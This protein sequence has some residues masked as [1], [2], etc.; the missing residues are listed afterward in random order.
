MTDGT[1]QE[2][3][4]PGRMRNEL[5]AREEP[6]SLHRDFPKNFPTW[7]LALLFCLTVRGGTSHSISAVEPVAVSMLSQH[8]SE[9]RWRDEAATSS[10]VLLRQDYLKHVNGNY[11]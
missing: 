6:A 5:C 8:R 3:F 2:K 9:R 7:V 1:E 10:L 11:L 4:H